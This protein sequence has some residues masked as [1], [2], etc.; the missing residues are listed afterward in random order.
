M[1]GAQ[2]CGIG[3]AA[4]LIANP[5]CVTW[6]DPSPEEFGFVRDGKETDMKAECL[7]VSSG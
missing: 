4:I 7:R 5:V 3:G 2:S 1:N 6:A